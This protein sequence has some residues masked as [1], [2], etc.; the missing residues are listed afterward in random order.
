MYAREDAVSYIPL[1]PESD[2]NRR[3]FREVLLLPFTPVNESSVV[4]GEV[5]QRI[6]L[7]KIWDDGFRMCLGITHHIGHTGLRPATVNRG[8]ARLASHQAHVHSRLR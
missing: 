2:N 7:G 5:N 8:V 4:L 3:P 6:G 1:S